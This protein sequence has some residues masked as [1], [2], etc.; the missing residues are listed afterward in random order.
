MPW[1]VL[2]WSEYTGPR[3][4]VANVERVDL[5]ITAFLSGSKSN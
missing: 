2:A 3:A 1:S 5:N 4:G